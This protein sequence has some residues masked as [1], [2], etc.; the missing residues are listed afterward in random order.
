MEHVPRDIA[1]LVQ[2]A[3]RS[4]PEAVNQ[5]FALL[6]QELHQLAERHL[7]RNGSALTLGA[8]TL[9]HEAYL[10]I[11]SRKNVVFP[12]RARFFAYASRAMRGLVIDYARRRRSRKRGGDYEI[13]T[14]TAGALPAGEDAGEELEALN[15][16]LGEL[17]ELDPALAELVDLHFFGGFTFGEIADLRQLSE[18]T[19]QR[20]WQKARLLLHHSL[21]DRSS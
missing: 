14:I 15:D 4:D 19:V 11:V 6:Y 21:R 9:V 3:D 10:S 8:T 2:R 17:G 1:E 7:Q 18:R 20:D 13:T 5:L 16:A 12:D